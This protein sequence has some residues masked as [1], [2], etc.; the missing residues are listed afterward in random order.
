MAGFTTAFSRTTLDAAIVDGDKIHWSENGSSAS[1]HVAA[2]AVAGWDASTDADPTIRDNTSALESAA[3]DADS[4]IITHFS[5][6]DTTGAT[7]KTDWT[8]LTAP[9]TLDTDDTLTVA[10]GA[11][12]VT[13]T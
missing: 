3:C 2:T 5:I 13:L 1:A 11:I 8:A 7:Q 4:I 9:R 10:A 12:D 6:F